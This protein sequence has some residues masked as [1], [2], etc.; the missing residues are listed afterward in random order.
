MCNKQDVALIYSIADN[1]QGVAL[2]GSMQHNQQDVTLID[3]MVHNHFGAVNI[4]QLANTFPR[5]AG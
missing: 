5:I 1:Q 3:S 2:I 4:A